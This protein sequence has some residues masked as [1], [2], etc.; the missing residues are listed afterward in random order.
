[1]AHVHVV[2]DS[3]SGLEIAR[4]GGLQLAFC[5]IGTW[6]M[7][8]LELEATGEDLLVFRDSSTYRVNVVYRRKDGN[9]GLV[10]PEF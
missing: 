2:I 7:T 3:Q 1:M 6:P 9:V 8:A 5:D 4:R 10:D